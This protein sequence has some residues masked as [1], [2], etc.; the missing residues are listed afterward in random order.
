[1]KWILRYIKSTIDVGLV[2]KKDTTSKQECIKYANSDYVKNL[3]KCRSTMGFTFT[4]AQVPMSWHSTLHPTA[5]LSTLE[6]E[7]MA[8]IKAMNE[9]I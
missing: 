6:V 1:M 7:H 3:D 9:T 4:L 8:M 2:F 5:A